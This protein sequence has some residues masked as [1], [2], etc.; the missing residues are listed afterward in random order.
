MYTARQTLLSPCVVPRRRVTRYAREV[1][2]LVLDHRL[3]ALQPKPPLP[4]PQLLLHQRL[5]LLLN[6]LPPLRV[7]RVLAGQRVARVRL[8]GHLRLRQHHA[9]L[10]V[11]RVPRAVLARHRG[12]LHLTLRLRRRL[13]V[14]RHHRQLLRLRR[15][16]RVPAPVQALQLV[17]HNGGP[18]HGSLQRRGLL[19]HEPAPLQHLLRRRLDPGHPR[20]HAARRRRQPLLRDAQLVFGEGAGLHVPLARGR[21]LVDGV[22]AVVD[23]RDHRVV[24]VDLPA[25]RT[26][27]PRLLLLRR[28]HDLAVRRVRL[29]HLRRLLLA[30]V[31]A[32]RAR[33][34]LLLHLG[35][36]EP[37]RAHLLRSRD[38]GGAA[39]GEL[40]AGL[41]HAGFEGRL[42]LVVAHAEVQRL[43]ERRVQLCQHRPLA[44]RQDAVPV[45]VGPEEEGVHRVGRKGDAQLLARGRPVVQAHH[46]RVLVGQVLVREPQLLLVAHVVVV[47]QGRRHLGRRRRRERG[48]DG[49][50]GGSVAQSLRRR[51]QK[52]GRGGGGG[53]GGG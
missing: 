34:R 25:H 10:H 16:Q 33:H 46:A 44:R 17:L 48:G 37:G 14:P 3:L 11:R 12:V 27:Q 35:D 24:A 26:L 43:K 7:R 13:R 38:L 21:R 29:L 1:R 31:R 22:H 18:A 49:R 36:A 19:A 8:P 51:T 45:R 41:M 30:L 20:V 2:S 6:H 47:L 4:Q 32:D 40:D 42:L 28:L 5:F 52:R 39:D 53:G 50:G 9:L 23:L 15:L